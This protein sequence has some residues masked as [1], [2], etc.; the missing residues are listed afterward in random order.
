MNRGTI[1]ALLAEPA[2]ALRPA[3]PSFIETD[4][5]MCLFFRDWGVGEP[6]LFLSSWATNTDL[7]Q[8]QMLSLSE[9]G[10]RCIAFDR[11]GHGR[12]SDPGRGFACDRLA[13]DLATVI[14]RL[15][16]RKL[17][18]V[19][20]SLGCGEIVRYMTR[21]GGGRVARIVLVAP[22]LPFMT[23]T[24]DHADGVL[25]SDGIAAMRAMLTS[26]LP[27]WLAANAR[28]FFGP[29]ASPALVD[30]GIGAFLGTSLKAALDCSRVVFD[31][32]YLA[33]LPRIAVPT[34]VIQG[35]QDVSCP[36]ELTGKKTAR[37]IPGSHLTVYEGGPHGLMF[38]HRARLNADL[39]TFI[40]G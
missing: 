17:T 3:S 31:T 11:R 26:D 36:L 34:L 14:D 2:A 6:V 40:R 7:W 29:D 39:L 38:S 5:G 19:G 33:E 9:Q 28:P 37:L 20:H 22:A 24:L 12:S 1:P 15:E 13:D 30:W 18:L 4:D 21:Y 25:D 35:D 23:K 32:D 27:G 16:L 10:Q 8:Y